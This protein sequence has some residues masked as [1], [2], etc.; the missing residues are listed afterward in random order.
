MGAKDLTSL[1]DAIIKEN[2]VGSNTCRR[3][4]SAPLNFLEQNTKELD[5]DS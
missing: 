1:M 2:D 3:I 5:E 4:E